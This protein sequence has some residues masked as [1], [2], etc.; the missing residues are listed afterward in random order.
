MSKERNMDQYRRLKTLRREMVVIAVMCAIAVLSRSIFFMLPQIKPM[1]AIV[2]LTG[3]LCGKRA[4][5]VTGAVSILLSDFMF[6]Q[7]PWTLFQMIGFCLLGMLAGLFC[8][9]FLLQNRKII[10]LFSIVCGILVAVVYGIIVDTGTV[11]MYMRPYSLHTALPVYIAGIPFN[12][13]HGIST[14]IFL[15]LMSGPVA[16]KLNRVK[17]KYQI[18]KN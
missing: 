11:I 5:A 13:M 1:A 4:G 8:K 14:T 15:L 17:Q 6:G 9:C 7:G 2:M 12:L 3:A 16:S 10:T 18:F